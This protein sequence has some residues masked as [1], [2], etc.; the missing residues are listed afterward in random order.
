MK[1]NLIIGILLLL[2]LGGTFFG[3]YKYYERMHPITHTTDTVLIFDTV[4]HYI[5]HNHYF[6]KVDTVLYPDSVLVPA[7]VD[8]AKILRNY[9][10]IY[11]YD[12]HWN[13]S[14]IEVNLTDT[15]TQN[16]IE[17]SDFLKYK[18]LRP[19]TVV[20]NVT[21]INNYNS[22]IYA[23]LVTDV[24][25]EF[26]AINLNYIGKNYQFG[27]GYMPTNKTIVGS[28]GIPIIKLK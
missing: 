23:S 7:D 21:N 5:D 1:K 22:Y 2:I 26:T 28:F 6:V 9:F 18:I 17:G 27:I 15:I 24:K 19:Q 25:F 3:G 16:K 11:K 14:I 4:T 10:A 12:R 20:T 13:D 8:T